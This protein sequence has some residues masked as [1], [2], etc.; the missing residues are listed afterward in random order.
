MRTCV[1]CRERSDKSDLLRLVWQEARVVV[2]ERQ[3][4]PGRGAYLHR[5]PE[6]L[7]QAVRRRTVSRA[8]RVASVDA[9]QVTIGVAPHV[10][11]P[12]PSLV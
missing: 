3:T 9:E 4:K 8:L 5:T 7:Q 2:D 6:C 11:Q 12:K 10:Q 1:G